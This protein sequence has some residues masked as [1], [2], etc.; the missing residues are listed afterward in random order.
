MAR[1]MFLFASLGMDGYDGGKGCE[2]FVQVTN[3]YRILRLWYSVINIFVCKW[4]FPCHIFG[5]QAY[6]VWDLSEGNSM[7]SCFH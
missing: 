5:G 1:L 7:G 4:G 2:E 3:M 6:Q